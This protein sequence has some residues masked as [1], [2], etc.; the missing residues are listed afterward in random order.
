MHNEPLH[1]QT[2][3]PLGYRAPLLS[4]SK[5]LL[6]S[7]CKKLNDTQIC[8][9]VHSWTC[10]ESVPAL[11]FQRI[12]KYQVLFL[13][14]LR[15]HQHPTEFSKQTLR[16]SSVI[17]S[18][19][20]TNH[21]SC[22]IMAIYSTF[23]FSA[24]NTTTA[25]ILLKV[26]WQRDTLL[27]YISPCSVLKINVFFLYSWFRASWLYINKIQRNATVCRCLFTAKLLYMF[28][29]SIAPVIRSTSNCNCSFWY[30]S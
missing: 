6:F 22:H 29:V 17:A 30:R 3:F 15:G 27:S 18:S 24:G 21:N 16:P 11:H 12:L 25:K 7:C 8:V 1:T 23:C 28:R 9:N 2:Y 13:F 5:G 4:H 14:V 20:I 26:I 10:V 19:A